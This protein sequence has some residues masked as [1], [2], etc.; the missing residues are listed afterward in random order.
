MLDQRRKRWAVRRWADVVQVL[1]KGVLLADILTCS[2]RPMKTKTY[3]KLKE[4]CNSQYYYT[5]RNLFEDKIAGF[6]VILKYD[7]QMLVLL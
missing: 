6:F 3:A 7:I 4:S 1:Y 5:I 2:T